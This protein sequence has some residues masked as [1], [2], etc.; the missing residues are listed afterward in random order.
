VKYIRNINSLYLLC[1]E[2]LGCEYA[3]KFGTPRI[4]TKE[5]MPGSAPK[6]RAEGVYVQKYL[7]L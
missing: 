3:E 6:V 5:N 4:F 2:F 1:R 7:Y